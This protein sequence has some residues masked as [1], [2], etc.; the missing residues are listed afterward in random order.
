MRYLLLIILSLLISLP[1]SAAELLIIQS[2]SNPLF[3]QTVRL[4]QNSCA[5]KNQTYIMS[6]YSEFDLGRIV[7]EERPRLVIAVGDKPLKESLNIRST[8]VL[9][10]MALAAEEKPQKRNITGVSMH[11]AAEHYLRLFKKLGLRRV[12]IVYSKAK[13]GAYIERAKKLAAEYGVELVPVQIKTPQEVGSAL[14][15]LKNSNIDS[16]WMVP[17]TTAVTAETLG[18]YFLMTENANLPLISFSRAYLEKGAVAVLEASRNKLTDQLCSRITQIL[19]GTDPGEIPVTD[20]AEV[21][22]HTNKT[23]AER[24][25]ISLSGTAQLFNSDRK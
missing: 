15:K 7:R 2:Q 17:D 23:V 3:D 16:I 8:P 11:A 12:G 22:L 1:A 13:S 14:S 21:S 4:L 24:L 25:N 10:T 9:F 19:G 18:S 5:G 20:I 6:D